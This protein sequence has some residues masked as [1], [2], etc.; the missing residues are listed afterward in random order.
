MS[1]KKNFV[2]KG[3]LYRSLVAT[4]LIANGVF[5]FITPVLAEGTAGGQPIDNT[6][7]ATYEDP[8]NPGETLNTTS[9]TVTVT[10]AEVAGITVTP[11]NTEFKDGGDVGG[12]GKINVGDS[13]YYNYTVTN[14]GNDPT[15]FRV[16]DQPT[17]TG[18]ATLDGKVEISY[19]G[20]Q[21]WEEVAQ[22]G[23]TSNSIDPDESVLVRVPVKVEPGAQSGDKI[24]VK[25]GDTPGDEQNVPRSSDGGDVYTVDNGDA[26]GVTGEVAGT[27][28]NGVREASATLE[29]V[30][31]SDLKTYTLAKVLKV[32]SN[33]TV[34]GADG[35]SDDTVTYDLSLQVENT[36][37]TGN[38]I[39]PAPLEGT[40]I[41]GLTGDNILVSD[42]I[43]VATKLESVVVPPGW[44]AVYTDT[45]VST[46]ATKATWQNLNPN[47]IPANVTRVGFVRTG[48]I[49][50]GQQVNGFKVTVKVTSTDSS[51]IVA[52][53]AQLFGESPTGKDVYD[54]S[55]DNNPSNYDPQTQLF[56][57]T[58]TPGE[59]PPDELPDSEIDDGSIDPT[60]RD[61]NGIP[62][63][64]ETLGVDTQNNNTGT[65]AGGEV[66][67]FTIS[68]VGDTSLLNGPKD[69]PDAV[70]ENDNNKDF[71]NKSS[72]VP[73]ETK[74]GTAIDPDG[75]SFTNTV[76][77]TGLAAADIVLQPIA[78]ETTTDLPDGTVVTITYD[79]QLATY[80]YNDG[81]FTLSSGTPV[82]IPQVAA[83]ATQNYGVEV[84][85]PAGT[86][87]STDTDVQ[88]GY[89]VPIKA[90]V[91][92][93][94]NDAPD[95][96]GNGNPA[97]NITIDRVYT[98]YLQMVKETRV[99][100]AT[101]PNVAPGDET[102]STTA[103]KPA[104]GNILEYRITY[105]NISEPQSGT[106]NV[107]L[108]ASDIKITE[109]GT[110]DTLGNNWAKDNDNNGEIDTSNITGSA[111]DSGNANIQ[112]TP[113]G[114][115]TGTTPTTDVT[116]YVVTVSKDVAPQE[117]RTFIFQRR[118]NGTGLTGNPPAPPAP[119]N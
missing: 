67:V 46:I 99:L 44:T 71:T 51:V 5:Q 63:E 107:I 90:F 111:K 88:R 14:V 28:A 87:L 77:N 15:K 104:P 10:V 59:L 78:P 30:V 4:A 32:R 80:T 83:N 113:N 2:K 97:E 11:A 23:T 8:N 103:K 119:P 1:Q 53:I 39:S 43:P 9:N 40:A 33:H 26:D 115:Q 62:D 36:D 95:D 20:G 45:A 75:V 64:A 73:A 16:P 100:K 54:E 114:D 24:T 58:T 3:H 61:N 79:S 21:T 41:P 85:L 35:P 70:A 50:P 91:D 84:N 72:L 52:N 27:P 89:P 18:P 68:Q 94:G 48:S 57:G 109:D 93:D 49:A 17:V 116:K 81:V 29:A 108:N 12:D 98:G 22:G 74:P 76:L 106:D 37:P 69:A 101:G 86:K 102:F 25:L 66:N 19:D 60:D 34:A 110:N 38:G 112:F 118:I 96:D 117:M 92:N 56:P 7:T 55:G 31:D 82:K 65:G 42:A 47:A 105:K 6:A 13:I